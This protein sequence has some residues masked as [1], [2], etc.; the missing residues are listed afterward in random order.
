MGGGWGC[1]LGSYAKQWI[2]LFK[3]VGWLV[4]FL[5][6]LMQYD[7]WIAQEEKPYSMILQMTCWQRSEYS[8]LFILANTNQAPLIK[9]WRRTL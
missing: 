5:S 1:G 2:H 6:I 7:S 8:K 9:K 3:F 4:I